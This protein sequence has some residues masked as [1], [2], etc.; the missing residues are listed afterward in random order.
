[1]ASHRVASV[2][3]LLL[4][5]DSTLTPADLADRMFAAATT[6]AVVG[7]PVGKEYPSN[8]MLY[9]GKINKRDISFPTTTPDLALI[10]VPTPNC[11]ADFESCNTDSDCCSGKCEGGNNNKS[12]K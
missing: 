12:C 6:D 5:E 3:A 8:E 7:V 2:T 9:T 11:G 10:P 4:E 1:M